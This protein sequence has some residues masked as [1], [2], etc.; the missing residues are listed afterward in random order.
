MLP[1]FMHRLA[2][3][4]FSSAF[5]DKNVYAV[6]ICFSCGLFCDHNKVTGQNVSTAGP[7]DKNY[8]LKYGKRQSGC[9]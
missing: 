5:R 7:G 2:S 4:L 1:A 3:V 8:A 9:L 6:V